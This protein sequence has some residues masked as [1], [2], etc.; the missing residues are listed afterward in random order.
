M[1][2][3]VFTLRAMIIYA[4]AAIRN[5]NKSAISRYGVEILAAIFVLNPAIDDNGIIF[6]PFSGIILCRLPICSG[7]LL[8]NFFFV[9]WIHF[10]EIEQ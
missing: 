9:V 10:T 3:K 5:W 2:I 6:I 7:N 1:P 8:G 4:V